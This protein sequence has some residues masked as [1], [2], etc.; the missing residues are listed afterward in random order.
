MMVYF[1]SSPIVKFIVLLCW[2]VNPVLLFCLSFLACL[3]V[4]DQY[5]G[6]FCLPA[7]YT[8]SLLKHGKSEYTFFFWQLCKDT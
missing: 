7:M 2:L 8:K 3:F 1:L 6:D 5:M 4:C